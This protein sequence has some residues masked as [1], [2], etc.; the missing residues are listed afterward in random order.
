[1]NTRLMT[2]WLALRFGIG[3]TATL[4]GLDKFLNLLADWGT[5]LSP[6]AVQFLPMPVGTFMGLA[7]VIEVA[8]GLAILTGWTRVGAYVASAW[9]LGVA[10]NLVLAGFYDIAVRDVVMAIAAYTLAK[11]A[12]VREEAPAAHRLEVAMGSMS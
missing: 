10:L 7:G 11:L 2:P 6:L 12:E 8:V 5:Y 3:L 9:L 4:A 1:M